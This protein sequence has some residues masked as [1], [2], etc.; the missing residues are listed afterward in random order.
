M[1]LKLDSTTIGFGVIVVL[2]PKNYCLQKQVP[3][4]TCDKNSFAVWRTSLKNLITEQL[5]DIRQWNSLHR[6]SFSLF[7]NQ[8]QTGVYLLQRNVV[9]S[10]SPDFSFGCCKWLLSQ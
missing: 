3:K 4:F 5:G 9:G 1:A 7:L 10:Q 6:S 2:V 8:A